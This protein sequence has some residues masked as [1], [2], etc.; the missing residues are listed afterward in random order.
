MHGATGLSAA[1]ICSA[2]WQDALLDAE[3][4]S[5]VQA[6]CGT[7]GTSA[8]ASRPAP[9]VNALPSAGT[10]VAA[11]LGAP[12][13]APAADVSKLGSVQAGAHSQGGTAAQSSVKAASEKSVANKTKHS[14]TGNVKETNPT[15][16]GD[17]AK[18]TTKK[19]PTPENPKAKADTKAATVSEPQ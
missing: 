11:P 4:L 7:P 6:R 1:Q 16:T 9:Q 2:R 3:L 5:Q 14:D 17:G 18:K 12:L 10:T 19:S 15:Q 8:S 13:S